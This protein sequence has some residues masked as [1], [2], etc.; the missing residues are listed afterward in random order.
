METLKRK[1]VC[2][3]CGEKKWRKEFH[4]NKASSDGLV[5]YCKECTRV[6]KRAEYARNRKV[7]DGISVRDD[8]M[9]FIHK[10]ISRKIYWDGNM[11][12]TLKRYF[13]TTLNDELAEMIGV[14][15]RTVVRKA[16]EMGLEKDQEWLSRIWEERR[17]LARTIAKRKGNPG[18]WKKGVHGNP[19][20]EF[21]PGHREDEETKAKRAAS[22][23]RWCLHH[24]KELK[25]RG[26]KV[27]ATRRR[28]QQ[29]ACAAE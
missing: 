28:N 29:A 12:S 10:G 16:R 6:I 18:C 14:S 13:A 26:A 21:K 1:K 27:W 22:V 20:G 4:L 23:R 5:S 7:P 2:P 19:A 11:I 9:K 17:R 15:K 8:G 3:K 25:E 24:P